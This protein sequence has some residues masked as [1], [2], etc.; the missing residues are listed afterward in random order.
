[1][2]LKKSVEKMARAASDC[3][4]HLRAFL[5]DAANLAKANRQCSA[6]REK[7]RKL[8]QASSKRA[9]SAVASASATANVPL[10]DLPQLPQPGLATADATSPRSA[11][12]ELYSGHCS[13]ALPDLPHDSS[14]SPHRW[15]LHASD[16]PSLA[17]GSGRAEVSLVRGNINEDAVA[18][19]RRAARE[20]ALV[21]QW[22]AVVGTEGQRT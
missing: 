18:S 4:K 10:S 13:H 20:M 12:S 1:M 11:S 8:D 21:Q 15:T 17:V 14:Q 22:D 19:K 7:A 16:F 2:L 5:D 3:R 9:D 6:L